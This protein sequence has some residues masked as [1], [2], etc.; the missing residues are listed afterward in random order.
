MMDVEQQSSQLCF[1]VEVDGDEDTLPVVV[2]HGE[3]DLA[4]GPQLA[5]RLAE[6]IDRGSEGVVIDLRDVSLL[7]RAGARA[8]ASVRRQLP[9]DGC[10]V[11]LRKP[12]R[13]VRTV[14]EVS[15]LDG[16]CVIED[17]D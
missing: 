13:L 4:T 17:F 12:S 1:A 10:Q 7:D 2:V 14:L 9:P 15:G 5:E 11:I 3:V 8:I 16:L 6:V